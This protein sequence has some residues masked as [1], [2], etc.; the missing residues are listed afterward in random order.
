M[1]RPT[2][3]AMAD[4]DVEAIARLRLEAFFEGTGRTLEEDVAGLRGLIAGDGFEAALV[5]RERGRPIGS[6]LLVRDEISSPHDLT[7][8]LAG[9][10]V[11][12][13]YR[14]GGIGTALV[15]TVEAHAASAGT[16]TLYLYTWQARG[17]YEALGWTAVETFKQDGEPML[18][19]SR[20]L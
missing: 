13:A 2:I 14:G 18:L 11:E 4:G 9:L 8:W 12:E 15:K 1:M 17:F 6:C 16:G 20:K 5:A 7:P 19:M 10:V 3:E